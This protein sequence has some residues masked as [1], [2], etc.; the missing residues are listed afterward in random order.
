MVGDR[1]RRGAGAAR[2]GR[3]AGGVPGEGRTAA[4]SRAEPAGELLRYP[5]PGAGSS[6][7]PVYVCGDRDLCK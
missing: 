5:A 6:G 2:R 4:G 3:R 1:R 7:K